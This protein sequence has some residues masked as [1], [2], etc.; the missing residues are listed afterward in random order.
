MSA[1]EEADEKASLGEPVSEA[2]CQVPILM[3]AFVCDLLLNSFLLE[4]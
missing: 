3:H 1:M 4:S 2:H